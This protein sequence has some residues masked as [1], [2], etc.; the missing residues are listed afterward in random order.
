V[1]EA[2]IALRQIRA[3]YNL[4]PGKNIEAV[5]VAGGA[6][7]GVYGSE[8][9]TIGRLARAT[10]RVV[11]HPPGDSAAHAVLSGGSALAVPLAGLIDVDKECARLRQEL[12]SLEKQLA[13]LEGRLGDEKFTARAPAHVVEAERA[14][15]AEWTARRRQLL[16]KVRT[17]CGG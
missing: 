11:D 14:K 12:A 13:A 5:V 15:L 2:V 1:R 6:A 10:L 9:T 16:D 17:L 8:A 7:A 4:A 3:D